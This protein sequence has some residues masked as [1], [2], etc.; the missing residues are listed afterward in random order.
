VIQWGVAHA[1]LPGEPKC[2]DSHLVKLFAGGALIAVVDGIGHGEE[3]CRAAE[4]A[5]GI[6]ESYAGENM[7]ALLRRCH[8][9][10]RG[11]RG[12]VMSVATFDFRQATMAWL[13]VG[14]VEGL[15]LRSP[16]AQAARETL[17]LRAGVLGHQLPVLQASA[18]HVYPGDTLIFTTDGIRNGFGLGPE[19]KNAPQQ[20]ADHI[21]AEDSK[22]T[23]D[24]LVLVAR[25]LGTDGVHR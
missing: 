22:G 2:G 24:S 18:V 25:Y 4:V 3:A 1:A 10:L 19:H 5:G 6:L 21:L 13:G 17:L 8:E 23:D 14:N 11:S 20:I 7:V 12:A 15:L 9:A 16:S